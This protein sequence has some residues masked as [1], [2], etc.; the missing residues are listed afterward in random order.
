MLNENFVQ[1]TPPDAEIFGAEPVVERN[2][3]EFSDQFL[4]KKLC[5]KGFHHQRDA[6]TIQ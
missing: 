3:G 5:E 2:G 4:E 1:S 6:M